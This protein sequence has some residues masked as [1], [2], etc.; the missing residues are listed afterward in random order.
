[1]QVSHEWLNEFVDLEGISPEEISYK[2]TMS[3]LEVEEIEYKKPAF[4]NIRT[5]KII[6]IENHPNADKLHLVTVDLGG[7]EKRVVCGAQNIEAG[8]IVPYATVGSKVL[9]RKTGESFEL[10]PIAIRGVES[11]GMLCS[12]DELGLADLQEED[13]ILILNRIY[14][15]VE[16]NIPLE[17]LMN[18]E[19][20]I[21]YHT[22][23]TANRGDEASVIG[24]ARELS[25]LFNRK[26]KFEKPQ[27]KNEGSTDFQVEIKDYE[28]CKYYSIAV[29]KNLKIKPSPEFIQRRITAAGMRP[30]NNI[31]DITN[32]VMLELGTPQHAFDL[33]KLNNYLCVRYAFEN[34]TLT[35]I[36]EVERK[37][38]PNQ[39]VVIA[40]KENPVCLGGVFGGFNSEIDSNTKNIALEAA[41]F[42]PHTNRKSARSVGYRSDASS[43]YERGVD[44]EMIASAMY[45]S[46]ELL[47]KYADAEFIGISKTGCD[48]P[49]D[50]T[51]TLRN[52]EIK[53]ILGIDI[54]QETQIEIL[55]N[56]GFELL[57]KNEIAAKYKTP[58]YRCNDVTRE[59]DLI[60]EV[61]RI[62]GFDKITPE[63]PNISEGAYINNDSKIIKTINNTMLAYGFDEIITSSLVGRNLC[64]MYL[65]PLDEEVKIEVLNPH[66]EDYAILRQSLSP[67]LLEVVKNNFDNGQKNFRMYEVGKTYIQKNTPNENESGAIEIRKLSGC[68]FGSTRNDLYNKKQDDFFTLKGAL[69]G[70]FEKLGLLKRI[71]FAPFEQNDR[72]NYEFIHPAQG[73]TVSILGKNKEPVG[74]IGKLHPVL[75]DKLKFN[76]PLY[77]FEINLEDIIS[78]VVLSDTKYK[79]IS[80]FGSVQRD[81]AFVAPKDI[82]IEELNKAIK[83][84][85]DKNIFKSSKIF[86]IYSGAGIEEGKKSFA[87]RIT[88][89]D[90]NKTLTDEIIQNEINKIKSGLEKQIIGLVL[91]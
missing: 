59:I 43:R 73:A 62:E 50:I 88:L 26:L 57:G 41:Y 39:T 47:K 30:I 21:I 49:D 48:K 9:D 65:N 66:S 25:A 63:L 80:V 32:Y 35:T 60:E 53:R 85:A 17:K 54:P 16:L 36:D 29:L 52:S 37:L 86:D 79:K 34:E 14:D 6:K 10:T 71:V 11:Q 51:I 12:Q 44:I 91:R 15:N 55:Q 72:Q 61:S 27:L 23:P 45:R 75:A 68:I 22:A 76:Q 42:T 82:T 20:E 4:S 90:E 74:F 19:D 83:K 70:L 40:T 3:G 67:S 13:G 5:A 24:I 56:L 78:S 18:L 84:S 77:L 81:I 64:N 33:D 8:Q 38:I 1:M 89:Q 28:I 58:S 7:V 87:F 69:E 31:V 46:V 2:L